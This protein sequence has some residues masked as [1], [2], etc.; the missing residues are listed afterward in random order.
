MESKKSYTLI[1]IQHGN[2]VTDVEDKRVVT[3][4]GR[5]IG[6]GTKEG[7]GTDRHTLLNIKEISSKGLRTAQGITRVIL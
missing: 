5:N 2:R 7:C 1:H 4:A 6:G 3:K